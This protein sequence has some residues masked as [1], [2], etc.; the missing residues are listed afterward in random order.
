MRDVARR[1]DLISLPLRLTMVADR[2]EAAIKR[3]QE[4]SRLDDLAE[5]EMDNVLKFIKEAQSGL[6]ITQSTSMHGYSREAISAYRISEKACSSE[7][8]DSGDARDTKQFLEALRQR[9]T[10]FLGSPDAVESAELDKL[11]AFFRRLAQVCLSLNVRVVERVSRA[12]PRGIP[13]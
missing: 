1:V 10:E 11:A 13:A 7:P 6:A 8:P 9:I 5:A 4:T 12:E 3:F 2:A